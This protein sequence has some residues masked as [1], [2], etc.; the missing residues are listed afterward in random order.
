[1]TYAY[2]NRQQEILKKYEIFLKEKTFSCD[3]GEAGYS[4]SVLWVYL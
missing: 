1:M 3:R 4:V 2:K